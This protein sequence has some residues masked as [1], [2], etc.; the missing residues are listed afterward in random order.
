MEGALLKIK[1]KKI[2]FLSN[3]WKHRYLL[4]MLL[5]TLIYFFI[6][7]YIPMYGVT[8][9]FK[10]Y[11]FSKGILGSPWVGLEHFNELFAPNSVFWRVLRNTI[12]ISGLKLMFVFTSGIAMALMINEL[13]KGVLKSIISNL[14]FL[15][16]F[17]SWVIIASIMLEMLS[18][19]RGIVNAVIQWAGGNPI[20]FFG[21]PSWFIPMVIASDMWQSA[22]W[23]SIIFLA[24]IAGIDP[25]QYEAAVMDG[26]SRFKQ[27]IHITLP[28]IMNV[29]V[30]MGLLNIGNILNA[31]FDQIFNMYNFRV[32]E[33][34]D[35]IDTYAYRV[36]LVEGSYSFSTA[37]SLFKNV[38][39]LMLV[40][41]ANKLAN[42]F[43]HKGIW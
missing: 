25:Q 43:G 22:G 36:G 6:F 28:S 32:Y 26:A 19:S 38:I 8:L 4:L 16:Y 42:R 34:A 9:A 20:Y 23:N 5:P 2:T 41:G 29:I 15:P 7:N 37:V 1:H 21:E 30:I 14:S 18:P 33:V 3:Y 11:Q 39:G 40:I 17:L 24:A 13:R 27:M 10:D 35:I 31:G 12:V